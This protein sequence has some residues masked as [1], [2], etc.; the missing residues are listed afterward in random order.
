MES[1]LKFAAPDD[2]EVHFFSA[3]DL[4]AKLRQFKPFY[5]AQP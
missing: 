5:P 4:L 1:I 2:V 3:F